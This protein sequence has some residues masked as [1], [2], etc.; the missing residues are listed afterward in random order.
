[1][2]THLVIPDGHAHPKYNNK[3]AMW[4]GK[5]IKD[6]KPDVVID[7]G[8]TADMPSLC[9]YD[10]GKKDFQG[11]TYASDISAHSEFQDMLWHEPRK[12]KKKLPL[13]VRLIGN[14]DQRI[15]RAITLQPELEGTV[16]YSDLDLERY[17]DVVVPYNGST[18]GTIE[19]DGVTYAHYLVSGNS[20]R[21]ISGDNHASML[22]QKM[23]VSC[24]VGHSHMLDFSMKT[25]ADGKKILGL[26][27]GV[28]QDYDSDYAGEGN[29]LWWRG[30]I[31]KRN[32][33]QG[34]YDL[35]TVSMDRLKR[36]YDK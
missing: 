27:A 30:A 12:S 4:L 3:R 14:H 24:T 18:P 33:H 11:R 10:K 28:F 15:E 5:L 16:S 20:G 34:T 35:E 25:R 26:V 7:L 23:F 32:V 8:D 1:M 19:I 6:V 29:K 13:R 31:I 21:P 2:T 36:E 17:Y 22:L 9:S